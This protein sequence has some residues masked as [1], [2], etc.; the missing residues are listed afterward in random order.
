MA[1]EY[2]LV[3]ALVVFYL[4]LQRQLGGT[5]GRELDD[6]AMLPFADDEAAARRVERATG[7]SRT[8]CGCRGTCDGGCPGRMDLPA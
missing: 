5:R 8:G 2:W 7:R 1:S 3:V 4:A 6:A